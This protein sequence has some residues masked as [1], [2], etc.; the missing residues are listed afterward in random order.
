MLCDLAIAGKIRGCELDKLGIV[1]V[2]SGGQIPNRA[3]VIQQKT[4]R[5]VQS[6]IMTEACRSLET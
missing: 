1:D 5:P 4:G 6:E 2:V 3:T